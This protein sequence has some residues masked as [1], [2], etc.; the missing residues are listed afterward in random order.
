MDLGCLKRCCM[1]LGGLQDPAD[2]LNAGSARAQAETWAADP[3]GL[4]CM[5]LGVGSQL[6]NIRPRGGV[7]SECQAHGAHNLDVLTATRRLL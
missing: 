4:R 5:V 7:K 3:A 6:A 2:V 1:A